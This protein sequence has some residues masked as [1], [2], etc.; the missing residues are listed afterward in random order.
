MPF[1]TVKVLEGK[2]V[3]QKRALVEKMSR[4]IAECWELPQDRI[5]IFIEDLAK[6]NYGKHGQL[7]VD[8]ES[9]MLPKSNMI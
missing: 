6:E 4:L 2:S 9:G 7:Y 3:E 5:F 1:V 8:L